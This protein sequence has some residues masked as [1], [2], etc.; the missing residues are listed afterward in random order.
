MV[1]CALQSFR[2]DLHSDKRI[3]IQV[4]SDNVTTVAYINHLG[5]PSQELSDLMETIWCTAEAMNVTLSARHLAGE[6]NQTADGLSHLA[7]THE[8]KLHPKLFQQIDKMW[9]PHTVD[10]FAA[11]HNRQLPE[12]NSLHWDPETSAVDAMA[13][14]W[15]HH[16]NFVNPPFCMLSQVLKLIETQQVQ[17]IVIAPW[18]PAQPWFR[19]LLQLSVTQPLLLP[20]NQRT[21]LRIQAKPEPWKNLGWQIYAWRV[22]GR[23]VFKREDGPIMAREDSLAVG[24][25]P[26]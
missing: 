26:P 22:C 15:H 8:W 18:W 2:K 10:R 9:G 25:L 24:L 16:N 7:S 6:L 3:H 14:D 19:K 4:L 5:E 11:W 12:Y 21:F 20:R 17:A 13:Q 23:S 1:L